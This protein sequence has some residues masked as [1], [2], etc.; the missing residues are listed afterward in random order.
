MDP[1]YARTYRELYRR[2]WWW[3]AREE[4]ILRELR[5]RQPP[6]GWRRILDVGCGD[7][8]FF[9][10]LSQFGAVEGV[11]PD[12]GLLDPKGRWRPSI[13]AIPFDEDFRPTRRYD[14]ILML[15]VLEHLAEPACALAHAR[16]LLE[17]GGLI[18]VTV[19][20]F[21]WLWTRHDDYNQHVQ[22][23]TRA[24]FRAVAGPAGLRIL[25]ERFLFQWLV[26]AKLAVRV[27]ESLR[28]GRSSPASL[29]PRPINRLLLL[30]T[31]FELAVARA[32]PLPFGSSLMVIAEAM[33]PT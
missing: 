13:H 33:P 31:R 32:L 5:R 19:P 16:T 29:P 10:R 3:R 24:T 1:E 11:E 30:A 20:A 12:V 17:P 28:Q 4:V 6:G 23:F 21:P 25:D 15:D 9:D 2:H 22:R 26:P 7:G 14:V 27:L 8:L 18:F